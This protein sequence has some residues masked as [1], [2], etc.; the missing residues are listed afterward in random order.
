[1]AMTR[2]IVMYNDG[3]VDNISLVLTPP[4]PTCDADFNADG[5]ADQD[6]VLC[7]IDTVAGNPGCAA[8]DADFN[9]DGNVD[10]DD[11]VAIINVVAGGNC[12]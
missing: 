12:P 2:S 4:G 8:Q 11:V 5:N 7:V 10:Q 3:Y 1:M 6:D 9:R